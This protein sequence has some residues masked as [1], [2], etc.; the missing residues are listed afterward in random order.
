MTAEELKDLREKTKALIDRADKPVLRM[1]KAM[2][3]VNETYVAETAFDLTPEQ[4][5]ELD[6]RIELDKTGLMEYSSWEKVIERI[7]AKKGK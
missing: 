5:A 3:E 4:E 1:L 2:L 6:R 7:I